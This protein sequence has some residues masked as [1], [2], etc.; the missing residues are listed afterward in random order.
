MFYTL[1]LLSMNTTQSPEIVPPD[2]LLADA[3]L[4]DQEIFCSALKDL[5]PKITVEVFD[6]GEALLKYLQN[7][8]FSRPP[9][10]IIIEYRMYDFTGPEIL[11]AIGFL[12]LFTTVPKIVRATVAFEKEIAECLSLGASRV[13]IKPATHSDQKQILQTLY[14]DFIEDS[15]AE[16][17]EQSEEASA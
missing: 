5:F 12:P 1:T 13:I 10:C 15:P 16:P 7:Y 2:I 3:D 4:E 8:S 6:K 9:K 14:S 11:Q 17:G